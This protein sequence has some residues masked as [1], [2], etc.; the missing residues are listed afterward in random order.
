[1]LPPPGQAHP[2]RAWAEGEEPRDLLGGQFFKVE[3]VEGDPQPVWQ[4]GEGGPEPG[5]FRGLELHRRIRTL[6]EGDHTPPP[7]GGGHPAAEIE[8]GAQEPGPAVLL[9]LEMFSALE[10]GQKYLL[11]H[12][13]RIRPAAGPSQCEAVH[14]FFVPLQDGGESLLRAQRLLCHITTSLRIIL[15]FAG[16]NVTVEADF[17]LQNPHPIFRCTIHPLGKQGSAS[18]HASRQPPSVPRYRKRE[19]K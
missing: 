15:H 16:G 2:H 1:M 7:G 9:L 5:L 13:V 18:S 10:I 19:G 12:V 4:R 17:F 11:K 3:Q 8:G 6:R 14:H